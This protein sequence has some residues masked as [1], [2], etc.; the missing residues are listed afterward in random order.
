L[1][2]R[3]AC[4]LNISL[5]VVFL[6]SKLDSFNAEFYQTFKEELIAIFLKVFHTIEIEGTLPNSFY[7]DTQ[8]T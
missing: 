4:L 3:E 2:E 6:S 8:T 5:K 7:F 1:G